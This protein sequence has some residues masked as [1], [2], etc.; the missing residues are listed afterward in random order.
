MST[1]KAE[2]ILLAAAVSKE[3]NALMRHLYLAAARRPS[4]SHQNE[5]QRSFLA[6]NMEK[7]KLLSC[8]AIISLSSVSKSSVLAQDLEDEMVSDR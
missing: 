1:V 4:F 2:I 5:S 6:I 7:W 8:I 3:R